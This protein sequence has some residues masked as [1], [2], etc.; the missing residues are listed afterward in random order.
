MVRLAP[1]LASDFFSTDSDEKTFKDPHITRIVVSAEPDTD[2]FH[3][4]S[5]WHEKY[6]EYMHIIEGKVQITIGATVKTYTSADGSV[7]IP[8]GTP[9]S[10]LGFKGVPLIIEETTDPSDSEKEIFFRNIMAGGKLTKNVLEGMN[11]CYHGDTIVAL[12]G[13]FKAFEKMLMIVFGY[14][15]ASLL[16]YERKL[17]AL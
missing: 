6:D 1:L 5:H 7:R 16:G 8:K 15:I 17:K 11:I 12:P 2:L 4:P 13:N 3:V 10:L 9:H 14:Y